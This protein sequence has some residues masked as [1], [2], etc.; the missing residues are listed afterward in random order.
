MNL[1]QLRGG[2][3]PQFRIP[4]RM[5]LPRQTVEPHKLFKMKC[6]LYKTW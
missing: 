5:S 3:S 4:D 1:I 2:L 6:D